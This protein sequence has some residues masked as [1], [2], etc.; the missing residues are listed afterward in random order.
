MTEK[1]YSEEEMLK[2]K[3]LSFRDGLAHSSPSPE[4][5]RRLA[6]LEKDIEKVISSNNIVSKFSV[7]MLVAIG[8]WVGTIQARQLRN[9]DDVHSVNENINILSDKVQKNDIGSA[10][11]R[12]KLTGIEVTLQEIK[13]KLDRR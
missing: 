5:T 10:E 7:G 6:E 3:D 13:S 11:I 12:A 2:A 4:T 8:I 1:T 9:I